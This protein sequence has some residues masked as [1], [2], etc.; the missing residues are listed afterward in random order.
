M[1]ATLDKHRSSQGCLG[2]SAK[3]GGLGFCG[4]LERAEPWHCSAAIIGL[5]GFAST[6]F[7]MLFFG[8]V[9]S[10]LTTLE[11]LIVSVSILCPLAATFPFSLWLCSAEC[12]AALS[13][14]FAVL[15]NVCTNFCL[16]GNCSLSP[17]WHLWSDAWISSGETDNFQLLNCVKGN[18]N[19]FILPLVF[20]ICCDPTC[21][22]DVGQLGLREWGLDVVVKGKD[23]SNEKEIALGQFSFLRTDQNCPKCCQNLSDFSHKNVKPIE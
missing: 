18:K 19:N 8:V 15:Q 16:C 23:T 20:Y 21:I 7:W 17:R 4:C 2:C 6:E 13:Q 9:F 10:S 11:L 22:R 5:L 3:R 14:S 12:L 1:L